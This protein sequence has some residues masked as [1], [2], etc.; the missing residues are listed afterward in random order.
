MNKV[1]SKTGWMTGVT[2]PHVEPPPIALIQE[3]HDGKLNKD[4]VELKLRRYLTSYTSDLCELKMCLFENGY[5]EEF[6]LFAINFNMT[7]VASGTL[8]AGAKIQC[9]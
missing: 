5:L 8:E 3:T 2:H 1:S 6:L 9:L 7:F 4:F